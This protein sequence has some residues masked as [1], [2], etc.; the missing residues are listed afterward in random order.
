MAAGKFDSLQHAVETFVRAAGRGED[1]VKSF[2]KLRT[3]RLG[4]RWRGQPLRFDLYL[5]LGGCVLQAFFDGGQ[6][7]GLGIVVSEDA[8]ADRVTHRVILN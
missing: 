5:Q 4:E 6:S 7:R 1:S 2:Q 8:D 3:S